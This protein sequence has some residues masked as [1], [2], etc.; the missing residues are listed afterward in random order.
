M[1][2]KYQYGGRGGGGGGGGRGGR[3]G[4]RGGRPNPYQVRQERRDRDFSGYG[5]YCEWSKTTA[6]EEGSQLLKQN[7]YPL[8][9]SGRENQEPVPPHPQSDGE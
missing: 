6:G 2:G 3:G 4:G 9:R 8:L 7:I 1:S 5:Q